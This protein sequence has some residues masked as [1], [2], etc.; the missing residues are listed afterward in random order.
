MSDEA[1]DETL[2]TRL[3][4][5]SDGLVHAVDELTSLLAQIEKL[6]RARNE[7]QPLKE[8]PSSEP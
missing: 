8:P 6:N 2:A 3:A 1:H 7:S 5:Y 4:D